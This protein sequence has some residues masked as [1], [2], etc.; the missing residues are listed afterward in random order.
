MTVAVKLQNAAAN[1]ANVSGLKF[2]GCIMASILSEVVSE[3]A[4]KVQSA[5]APVM[6]PE[7]L[8]VAQDA[9]GSWKIDDQE[10]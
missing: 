8:K 5:F 7:T 10:S 1:P 6:L 9:Q 4:C 3:R 2:V